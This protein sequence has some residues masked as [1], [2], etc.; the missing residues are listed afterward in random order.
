MKPSTPPE[1]LNELAQLQGLITL[2]SDVSKKAAKQD[3]DW[4][5]ELL[6]QIRTEFER[7]RREQRNV[8]QQLTAG[9][10]DLMEQIVRRAT[11]EEPV[12]ERA[13]P[14]SVDICS[15][16]DEGSEVRPTALLVVEPS[17]ALG[18]LV[19]VPVVELAEARSTPRATESVEASEEAPPMES[20]FQP[21]YRG[22]C[23]PSN[24]TGSRARLF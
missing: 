23:V 17:G 6:Q 4:V 13:C 8:L 9:T 2:C 15:D 14:A 21:V 7:Q 12:A 3:A 18:I 1:P 24:V 20:L 11:P 16:G 10:K 5:R 19:G 22:Q